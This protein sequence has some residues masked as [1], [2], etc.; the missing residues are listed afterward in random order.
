MHIP[1]CPE[2]SHRE[3]CSELESPPDSG[4][5][6]GPQQTST[7][8][9]PWAHQGWNQFSPHSGPCSQHRQKP[10]PHRMGPPFF[11]PIAISCLGNHLLK[12][13]SSSSFLTPAPAA[14]L[15][16]EPIPRKQQAE[17]HFFR[18]AESCPWG[19]RDNSS[20]GVTQ[21]IYSLPSTSPMAGG[22]QSYLP[23]ESTNHV[24]DL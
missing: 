17:C 5:G 10:Q 24:L 15:L 20:R 1:S 13:F 12:L 16:L 6:L 14:A 11:S 2:I 8:P 4:L 21:Q 9:Q 18:V 23:K 22:L 19:R 3:L 7:A